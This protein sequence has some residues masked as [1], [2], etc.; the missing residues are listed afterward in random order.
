MLRTSIGN[1]W[2]YGMGP[3]RV[4]IWNEFIYERTDPGARSG[5]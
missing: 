1:G 2:M 4:T 5:V 3:V